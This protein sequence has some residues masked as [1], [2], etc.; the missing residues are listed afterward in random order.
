[1]RNLSVLI[2]CQLISATG[3]IVMVTLGGIL[4]ASLSGD[5]T[6]A[7][8]PVSA[9][10]VAVAL[11][12]VP[13][14][15]I[16]QR[17][18][19][20]YGFALA[21][22]SAVLAMLS[23][24]FSL[25][26]QSF[27]MLTASMMLFGVNMAFTQQYRY[28]AAESVDSRFTARAISFVL[29]GAIG[30]AILGPELATRGQFALGAGEY[31]GTLV[32]VSFLYVLQACLLLLLRGHDRPQREE[33]GQARPSLKNLVVRPIFAV[34]VLSGAA[35]Y[36]LM[37]MIM[38]A[39][40]LS[41]HINDG[42]SIEQTANVI[43]M[44][45]LGMYVPS[46]VSGFLIDRLGVVRLMLTGVAVFLATSLI[47]MNGQSVM[48]YWWALLALGVG[49]NFLYVGGTTMLTYAYT[50]EEKFKAQAFNEFVVFGMSAAASFLAGVI[51]HQFGW[52][53]LMWIPLPVL[54]VTGV[55]LLAVSSRVRSRRILEL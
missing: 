20:R 53:S 12:S 30:G 16:M 35:A 11:S 38:T 24:A 50:Q 5:P 43:R 2:L 32:A 34:A 44:H 39:T 28:A 10:V 27:G 6:L 52:L 33:R 8:L 55:A 51:M 13:A 49:W 7:T 29:L 23:A 42:Y 26:I 9:L 15:L 4:G 45:V 47:G 31:T 22:G 21:S 37:T 54:L 40:P 48:H 1:M 25:S 36:G 19:R 41:M 14:T 17:I 18:G 46:L 3:S